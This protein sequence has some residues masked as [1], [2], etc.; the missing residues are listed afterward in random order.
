MAT[1]IL[2]LRDFTYSYGNIEV[3]HGINLKVEEGECV[4]IIGANGAGKTTTM[5]AI[6][7]LLSPKG[8]G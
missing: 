1:P 4:T 3:V 7:G 8:I 6:S 5:Q 2:E